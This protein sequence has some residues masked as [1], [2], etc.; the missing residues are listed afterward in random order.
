[1]KH[2]HICMCIT[3]WQ[4]KSLEEAVICLLYITFVRILTDIWMIADNSI[5]FSC[6]IYSVIVAWTWNA[7]RYS[8]GLHERYWRL[9]VAISSL[10]RKYLGAI[11]NHYLYQLC[12]VQCTMREGRLTLNGCLSLKPFNALTSYKRS[13]DFCVSSERLSRRCNL[14]L[15]I[16]K[17]LA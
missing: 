10:R 17:A 15:Q 6:A 3:H 2:K 5:N 7:I 4:T 13:L 1:M 8:C 9:L 16:S 12:T 11:L 14:F